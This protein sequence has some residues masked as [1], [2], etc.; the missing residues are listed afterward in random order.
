MGVENFRLR[1]ACFDSESDQTAFV[2]PFD[3]R[4][5][6]GLPAISFRVHCIP[7]VSSRA[8]NRHRAA[9]SGGVFVFFIAR[10]SP[11]FYRP[12]A[13]PQVGGCGPGFG[14]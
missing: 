9:S 4:D 8:V 11:R 5:N 7:A 1:F 6:V 13:A 14:P 12:S 3:D 2:Y 10:D